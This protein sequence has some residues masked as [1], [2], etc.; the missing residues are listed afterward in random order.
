MLTKPSPLRRVSIVILEDQ[1]GHVTLQLRDDILTIPHPNQWALFGG[2]VEDGEEADTA[3]LREIT[4]EL[5]ITLVPHKLTRLH[6]FQV[7][8]GKEHHLFYYGLDGEMKKAI[9][10]EGQRF[11]RFSVN[12]IQQNQLDGRLLV[13]SHLQMLRW[14][15]HQPHPSAG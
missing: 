10:T 5:T 14:Y 11:A 9:L 1:Q 13:P 4:E 7:E 6:T 3:V 15:W 12:A 8:A 2:H